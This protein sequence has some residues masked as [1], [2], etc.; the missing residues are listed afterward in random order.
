VRSGHDRVRGEGQ[1]AIG[2]LTEDDRTAALVQP[3]L[4]GD[5]TAVVRHQI[6]R[7]RVQLGADLSVV[8]KQLL[9][10]DRSPA[11]YA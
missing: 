1:R 9:D 2:E 10:G 4:E 7:E 8:S 6:L 11:L 5:R 3:P